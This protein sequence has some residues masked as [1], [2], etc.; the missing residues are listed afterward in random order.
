MQSILFWRRRRD[1]NP[2][3][4]FPTYT[5]SRGASSAYLSTSPNRIMKNIKKC[6][7][8][9]EIRTLGT[10]VSLVFKT[11][12]LNHSDTS[13]D[14]RSWSLSFAT[15]ETSLAYFT[16]SVKQKCKKDAKFNF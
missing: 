14:I 7:G 16:H 15:A 1:S 5:L 13:P 8:E 3:A 12:S 10:C 4:G 11:S 9:E 2:R 6:G